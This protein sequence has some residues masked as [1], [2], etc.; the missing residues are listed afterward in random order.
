MR[1]LIA[2]M[3]ISLDGK[4]ADANGYAD[5][6]SAWSDDYDV[7]PQVDAC[8]L[9]AGMYP[10]YE[11]YWTTIRN[12]PAKP[13]AMTGKTTTPAEIVW[14]H[15]AA[16]T[17]HYVL[18]KALSAA[19]WPNTRFLRNVADVAALK[20]QEGKDIYLVGGGRTTAGLIDAGSSMSSGC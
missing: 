1:K 5:W 15:F 19:A 10:G 16:E 2:G 12:E 11:A 7:M 18:S 3:K 17:P 13:L 14:A 6:V 4:T 9:G 20:R 8:V